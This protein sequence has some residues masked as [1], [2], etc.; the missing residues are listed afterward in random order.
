MPTPIRTNMDYAKRLKRQKLRKDREPLFKE[1]DAKFMRALEDSNTEEI[2]RLKSIKQQLRDVTA[3][4]EIE[5][6][7]TEED[8]K[9]VRPPVL[10]ADI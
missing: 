7:E 4:P 6:A 3:V 5:A 8:L 9:V 2:E 1:A 10:D